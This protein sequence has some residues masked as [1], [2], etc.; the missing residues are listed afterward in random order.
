MLKRPSAI[1]LI[2]TAMVVTATAQESPAAQKPTETPTTQPARTAAQGANIRVEVT[3]TDQRSDAQTPPKTVLLLI[4]DN[5]NGRVRTGRGNAALN[6]DVRPQIVR[7]GRVRLMVSLEFTA[8]EGTDRPLQPPVQ[9]SLVA[10]VDDGKSLVV[11]QSAD[12][13]SDRKVRV[14]VKATIVR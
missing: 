1:L 6:L 5:Q 8:Q 14:E 2:A 13:G 7:E 12:P 10:L 9:A 4:E 3:I 11:S